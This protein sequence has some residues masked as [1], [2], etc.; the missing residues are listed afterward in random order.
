MSTFADK[1][2]RDGRFPPVTVQITPLDGSGNMKVERFISYT[3]ASSIVVP[4]DTF[5]FEFRMPDDGTILDIAQDGDIISIF[6]NG[7][8][9]SQGIIDQTV[10]DVDGESGERVALAGRNLLCQLEDQDSVSS[11]SS[12]IWGQT[13][14]IDAVLGKLLAD[15]RIA[16]D[17]VNKG[18]PDSAALFATEPGESKMTSLMRYLEPFNSLAWQDSNGK[19]VVGKPSFDASSSGDIYALKKQKKSNVLSMQVTRSSTT[20]PNVIIPCW[21]GT[22]TVQYIASKQQAMNN[23]A[24]GPKRLLAGGHRVVKSCVV[25]TPDAN[26]TQGKTDS[27]L[28]NAGDASFLQAF[29]KR[30]IASANMGELLVTA[31]VPGHYNDDGKPYAIDQVYHVLSDRAK[32]DEFMYL[33]GVEYSLTEERGQTTTMHLCKL[34]TIVADTKSKTAAA[35]DAGNF[36]GGIA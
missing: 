8:Q 36:G 22:E 24:A 14:K 18:V 31:T 9:I 4:V 30:I 28:L 35:D 3:F 11:D 10:F 17:F 27:I 5:S 26:T 2:A 20:I 21:T 29:A 19:L 33:Y 25:S 6:A 32:L 12:P 13:M 1:L 7:V 23:S 34:N 16:T 15:T